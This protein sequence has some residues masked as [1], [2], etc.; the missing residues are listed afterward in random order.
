MT[1]APNL[2]ERR[3]EELVEIGRAQ[4]PSIA[5]AWTDHNAHD[6][7]IT[8]MEL[9]AWV[10]EA[11]LYSLS[12]QRHD[13]R[14]AYAALLGISPSGTKAAQGLIWSDP[15]DLNSPSA[16][17]ATSMVISPD[18]IINVVDSETPTFRPV[19][20][21][22]WVPG[23]IDALQAHLA[24]G[25]MIDL[26]ATNK[27]GT[28]AFSPLGENAGVRDVLRM[29]YSCRGDSGLFPQNRTDTNGALWPIGVR[30]ALPAAQT[31]ASSK[32]R[33]TCCRRV[34]ATLIA[35]NV[36]TELEVLYDSSEGLL[37][38][39]VLLV[40]LDNVVGSPQTFTIELR[41][42]NG[43]PRPPRLVRIE[44][45]VIPII[46]GSAINQELHVANGLPDWSFPL[47][48]PGLRF[49]EGEKPLQIE[50]AEASGQ[51]VWEQCQSLSDRGPNEKVYELD[52]N[53]GEVRFGN[54][55]NG[56]IPPSDSQVL[57]TYA[58]CD[59]D[60]GNVARN[61]K[62]KVAGFG[63]AFG[64]NPDP[65]TGGVASSDLI[66]QRREGRRR[67]TEDH[68]LINSQ[69]LTVAATSL[70]LLQVARV[71]VVPPDDKLPQTGTTT[72]VAMRQRASAVEPEQPPETRRWLEAVRSRLAPRMP[73]GSR[74]AVVAPDYIE[75]SVEATL[76]AETGLDPANVKE[77]VSETLQKK[78]A[79]ISSSSN[80]APRRP[81][82]PV[83]TRD[84]AAWMRGTNGVSRVVAVRLLDATGHQSDE[85]SA[86]SNGLPKWLASSSSITVQRPASGGAA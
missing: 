10:A 72:L 35:G 48:V 82:V 22:L 28:V 23:Q 68:A 73:L 19:R 2:F 80:V 52:V 59:G 74:L 49:A 9:L 17:I 40:S 29:T 12:R 71:W 34:T 79:L 7:G 3:F 42:P 5:P 69:D 20:K 11:Q 53:K 85:I 37:Q 43:F 86:P 81:G 32:D 30:A 83:T 47:N 66:G 24:D 77:Q 60:T 76:Q 75:F 46:Q 4:L 54:G 51:A 44:P 16:T 70:S 1:L 50:V 25:S 38:T 33:V 41:C 78:L 45:N 39:G 57:A 63:G 56:R 65:V 8:L 27:R 26:T 13:E 62:W 31:T 58:V 64:V 55:I 15:L 67:S 21:L 36:H 84:V 14:T 61:R 18:A 6:P